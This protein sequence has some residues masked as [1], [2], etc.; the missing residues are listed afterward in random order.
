MAETE[1]QKKSTP[2][3]TPKK[4]KRKVTTKKRTKK[5]IPKKK[6]KY[7]KRKPI[8]YEFGR[9]SKY[10]P[11][12]CKD[13]VKYFDIP[14]FVKKE[15]TKDHLGRTFTYKID[16]PNRI[17]LFEGFARFINVN[18]D[19]VVEWAKVHKN[20]SVAYKIAKGLQKEMLV[21]L[22]VN[23]YL[24]SPYAIFLTKNITNFRDK[25]ETDITSGGD[26]IESVNLT[27][28]TESLKNKTTDELQREAQKQVN[29]KRKV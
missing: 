13:I 24:N 5:T 6:R 2:K 23:G 19:T 27:S 14:Y 1:K 20:F 4:T 15:I 16:V 8:D 25:V 18:T 17:P 22:A 9:P 21:Y 11:K 28:F 26:K 10:R 7:T 12:F 29:N 3:A